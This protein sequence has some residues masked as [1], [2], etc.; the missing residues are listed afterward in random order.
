LIFEI[1]IPLIRHPVNLYRQPPD[2]FTRTPPPAT[3]NTDHQKRLAKAKPPGHPEHTTTL[4]FLHGLNF[5]GPVPDP[6]FSGIDKTANYCIIY[7][8]VPDPLLQT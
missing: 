4:S 6:D 7:L 5:S 1:K 2:S 8:I 3:I